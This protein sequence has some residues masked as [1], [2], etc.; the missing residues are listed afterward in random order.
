M[1]Q[2]FP[3]LTAPDDRPALTVDDVT[4]TR[5]ALVD[6]CARHAAA[7]A[8]LGV[9]AGDRVGVWTQADLRTPVVLAAHALCGVVSVPLNPRLGAR[10]A[11]ADD[12]AEAGSRRGRLVAAGLVRAPVVALVAGRLARAVVVA[13]GL[14]RRRRRT[15]PGVLG[16][17]EPVQLAPV[18]EDAA[19]VGA[20]VDVD[21]VALV[22]AHG[23]VTLRAG[24]FHARA[25]GARGQ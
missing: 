25:T 21:A 10:E 20:L 12:G 17:D 24:Q 1:S 13:V 14:S 3:C 15:V 23:S 2:L 22:G 7:L 8:R 16:V 18:E 9:R 5:R 6:A 11:A 4:L 19:A